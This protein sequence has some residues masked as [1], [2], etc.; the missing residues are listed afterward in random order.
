MAGAIGIQQQRA[1][2]VGNSCIVARSG[3]QFRGEIFGD[4][5][6]V[7]PN[8]LETDVA[9]QMHKIA[10]VDAQPGC[11]KHHQVRR[12]RNIGEHIADGTDADRGVG[13]FL[14][15]CVVSQ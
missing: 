14:I 11:R 13:I 8:S 7:A 9:G 12:R 4:S 15:R 3:A 5:F 2:A 6:N 10:H 1:F